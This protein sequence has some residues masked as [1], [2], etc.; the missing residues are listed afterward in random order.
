MVTAMS[1]VDARSRLAGS[2]FA[3][4]RW[5]E[6]TG[7]TNEDLLELARSSEACDVVLAA[8]S[9]TAGRGRLDRSW[10]A[11]PGSSLLVSVLLRPGLSMPEA[12]LVTMALGIAAAEACRSR[13]GCGP[14]LKWPN[15]LV[16]E[17]VGDDRRDRK[18]GGILA[19]TVVS[20]G[21]LEALVVG[22]GLNVNWPEVPDGLAG[23]ATSLNLVVGHDVDREDL[24]VAVLVGFEELYDRLIGEAGRD[25]LRERYARLSATLGRSVRVELADEALEGVAV[26]VTSGGQLIVETGF[27]FREITVGDVIHLHPA[28]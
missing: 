5:V 6:Q 14:L 1:G 15:D 12:H 18:V 9:Q 28:G 13:T 3:D 2:R 25:W 7:S 8:E 27:G 16:V 24:L 4:L 22:L 26:G 10:E 17:G 21:R 11:P 19:E 23:I 20:G